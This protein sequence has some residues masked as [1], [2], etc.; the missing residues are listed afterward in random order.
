MV[1]DMACLLLIIMKRHI[2]KTGTVMLMPLCAV[3]L[4]FIASLGVEWLAAGTLS[5]QRTI[6]AVILDNNGYAVCRALER[7]GNFQLA[8]IT[9]EDG[10][11]GIGLLASGIQTGRSYCF[12]RQPSPE[13]GRQTLYR[14][15]AVNSQAAGVNPL[16]DPHSVEA[17]DWQVVKIAGNAVLITFRLRELRWG[18]ERDYHV[19]LTLF[20]ADYDKKATAPSQH[21]F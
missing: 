5:W 1:N 12:F 4:L 16:T 13:N 9:L 6:A 11:Y 18:E 21:S 14:S 10:K 8:D 15:V 3:C 17:V 20:N 2:R 19:F 7:D